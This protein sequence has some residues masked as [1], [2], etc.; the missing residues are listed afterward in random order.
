MMIEELLLSYNFTPDSRLNRRC[1]IFED[2]KLYFSTFHIS[3]C[4]RVLEENLGV[5]FIIR[6]GRGHLREFLERV[7]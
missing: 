4:E 5:G 7:W 6:T 3:T 1:G 2:H